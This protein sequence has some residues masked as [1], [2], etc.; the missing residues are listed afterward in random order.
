MNYQP[1][2]PEPA[3]GTIDAKTLNLIRAANL[4]NI[5]KK[6]KA[7]K[8]L[9]KSEL[10]LLESAPTTQPK[11]QWHPNK[12]SNGKKATAAEIEE[13]VEFVAKLL[14]QDKTTSEIRREV[15]SNWPVHWQTVMEY[16]RRAKQYLQKRVQISAEEA[17]GIGMAHL[18]DVMANGKGSER[19]AS[20]RLYFEIFGC[21]PPTVVRDSRTPGDSVSIS[22]APTAA[23]ISIIITGGILPQPKHPAQIEPAKPV[24]GTQ[25]KV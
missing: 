12:K 25:P 13:R 2:A 24:D 9:A 3:A 4:A 11:P 20:V 8:T 23:P 14:L 21:F 6:V 10:E 16:T 17:K 18:A 5:V 22:G 1:P 19:V 15:Q 7:G